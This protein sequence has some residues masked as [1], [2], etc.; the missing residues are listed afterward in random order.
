MDWCDWKYGVLYTGGGSQ[1]KTIRQW[2][3][4]LFK[5][6]KR[7]HTE[8]QVSS[9]HCLSKYKELVTAHGFYTNDLNLWKF[10]KMKHVKSFGSHD[11]R[12]LH[13]AVSPD[14]SKLI[15]LGPDENL[16]FWKIGEECS[17]K[18]RRDSLLI[19]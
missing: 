13:T 19:R 7:V 15:S 5:E 8:S 6:I 3:V 11:S 4:N 1:D 17:S 10:D 2:D 16:K 18:S 9:V 12:I 14:Q